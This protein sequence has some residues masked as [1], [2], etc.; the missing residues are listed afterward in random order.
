MIHPEPPPTHTPKIKQQLNKNYIIITIIITRVI[1][2]THHA[3]LTVHLDVWVMCNELQCG[4]TCDC[5]CQSTGIVLQTQTDT[6]THVSYQD[7]GNLI[8][9]DVCQCA[10]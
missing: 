5:D 6:E 9:K 1:L 8:I 3:G 7:H 10:F 2:I 4:F